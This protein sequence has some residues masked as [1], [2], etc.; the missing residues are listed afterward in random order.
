MSDILDTRGDVLLSMLEQQSGQLL[1]AMIEISD[2][3]NEVCVH[4]YQEQ[5][6]KGEMTTDQIKSVMDELA[7]MG[8]LVLTISGGEATLRPDFLEL[9]QHARK[10]SF[11]I[12]LFTNGLTMTRELAAELHKLAV[13]VV[14]ISL[15]SHRADVHD[16]ITGVP[17]SFERTTAGIRYLAELGVDVH[18]KSP[19]MGANE[20][21]L[22]ALRAFAASIGAS[23]FSADP[24]VLMPREGGDRAPERLTRSQH[25]FEAQLASVQ[26]ANN[27]QP[28]GAKPRGANRQGQICGAGASIHVEPNGELRPCTM[29]ELNLGNALEGVAAARENS[30]VTRELR[31]L[32]WSDIHG[33]RRCDLA[34]VCVR[35]YASALA[36]V[37]D[38]LGPYPS[39]CNDA[40]SVYRVRTGEAVETI[41]GDRADVTVGPYEHVAGSTFRTVLDLISADDDALAAHLGWTR[42]AGG[43]L[44]DPGAR[45][46]PGELVQ[47]RRPGSK[48]SRPMQV[49]ALSS[50]SPG[51]AVPHSGSESLLNH[52]VVTDS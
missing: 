1:R 16:F 27:V 6:T 43:A 20:A 8:V 52:S 41:A 4:C 18:V 9:L 23:S 44:P 5:G 50:S 19:T 14:E 2:R 37:G 11:A 39:A 24:G 31:S 47:L 38:A 40:R 3:C 28:P 10:R 25:T 36:E 17:R 30:A 35:C 21:E 13:H 12:R 34:N 22:S 48:R 29:L 46:R 32:R 26:S 33:C 42:R 45:V 49:P 51:A 7:Q 15:Y